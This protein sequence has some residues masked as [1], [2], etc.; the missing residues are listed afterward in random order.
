[1]T[2]LEKIQALRQ[3]LHQ[4]NY[5]YYILDNPTISDYEFDQKLSILQHLEAQNPQWFDSNSPTQR[6][7]GGLT[8]SFETVAH[9]FPMYSLENS[10]SIDELTL[11]IERVHRRLL[12]E[13]LDTGISDVA[14]TCELKYDG[15]SISLTYTQGLLVRALSRGDGVQG[16][17]VTQNV[18]KINTVPLVLQ[19]D[20]P[21]D[22][23]IRGEIVLPKEAFA[24]LNEDRIAKGEVAFMN[25]RNT[26][27]G[28]LKLQDS[29]VVEA[30]GLQCLL[31]SVAAEQSVY[32]SQYGMLQ[33]AKKMGFF[34]PETA[35]RC[36]SIEEIKAFIE[37]WEHLR[38]SLPYEIDGV[39]IKVDDIRLQERLGYTAKA[40]R[41]AMAYK[42]KAEQVMTRLES[43]SYQVGRTGAV[44]PVANLNPVYLAGTVVKRASL[45]NADQ[46]EKLDLHIGDTV[47]LEKGGDIIPKV[48][49][50][51]PTK[52][53][54]GALAVHF[55]E[56][57]PECKAALVRKE[58]EAL[59]YCLNEDQCPPQ[60]IGR[61]Q[62]FC[63]RKAMDIEGIGEETVTLLVSQQ[64]IENIGDLYLLTPESLQG[65]PRLGE[66]SIANLLEGIEK[67]KDQPFDKVLF[68]LGIRHV[69]E[70]VA[71][72]LAKAFFSLEQLKQAS[73]ESLVAVEDV[74][75]RIAQSVFSYLRDPKNEPILE[76]L[77]VAG[78]NLELN[79]TVKMTGSKLAHQKIVVSGVFE[80]YS[81]DEMKLL[82]ERN[83]GQ[84]MGSISSKTDLIVAGDQMGPSK[85]KKA[86]EL[87]IS[88]I[89]EKQLLELLGL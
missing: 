6:V 76:Q 7:G 41:W 35:K 11:W 16:D 79:E 51:E 43:V 36:R 62:H 3:E 60:I 44:T 24:R 30:R 58:G 27:S 67:S 73:L 66:L 75:E 50:V 26:A 9:R 63:S 33:Q 34:V 83:G 21:A 84:L 77:K 52:R 74:G 78:L 82:I 23:D 89:T 40:P 2:E 38:S 5:N 88:I 49:S 28:T 85:R 69:G 10:Y 42:F 56:H 31:Y 57:C 15:A 54:P 72:K 53:I 48:I 86:E 25:P 20:Y 39:V 68:G 4:H 65:I 80:R 1:M 71:K 14:F 32:T 8:K 12:D 46:I 29:A 17:D 37:R 87:S 13:G 18:K 81:R 64:V 47:Y 55:P 19:G 45:H 70:T 22:F 59:H 61:I